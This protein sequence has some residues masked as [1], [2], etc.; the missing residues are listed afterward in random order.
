[1]VLP[2]GVNYKP[3]DLEKYTID[4]FGMPSGTITCKIV[5][6]GL[7]DRVIIDCSEVYPILNALDESVDFSGYL[8]F[9]N[10]SDMGLFYDF[11]LSIEDISIYAPLNVVPG[12]SVNYLDNKGVQLLLRPTIDFSLFE[13]HPQ[14]LLIDYSSVVDYKTGDCGY[15]LEK[16]GGQ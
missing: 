11:K 9:N 13:L 4:L 5:D 7:L 10:L 3:K 16:I 14:T 2:A 8:R 6:I 15:L 1:M 12:L